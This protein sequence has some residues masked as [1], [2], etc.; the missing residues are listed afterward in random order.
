MAE[1]DTL[2]GRIAGAPISWG[3]CEVPGWGTQLDVD[4]VLGEMAELGIRATELGADGWLPTELPA[5]QEALSR[6]GLSPV[7]GFVPLVLHDPDRWTATEVIARST[8]A[9][10]AATGARMFVTCVVADPDDWSRPTLTD[11]DWDTLADNLERVEAICAAEGLTQVL[12]P[13]VDSLIE[14]VGE[15]DRILGATQIKLC[16]DTGH[17]AIGGADIADFTAR[18]AYRV[19][20]VHCKDVRLDVAT[21]MN[22]GELTLMQAVQAGVFV[23]LGHGDLPL[24]KAF[25]TLEAHGYDGWYVLEQDIAITGPPPSPRTGPFQDTQASLDWLGSVGTKLH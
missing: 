21:R 12:H 14:K 24:A 17:L 5:L 18:W 4:R 22:A 3:I 15:A 13:H 25:E 8:A 1:E 7:G 11:A 19:G 20:H 9:R 6:H 16:L 23:P 10:F 2:H